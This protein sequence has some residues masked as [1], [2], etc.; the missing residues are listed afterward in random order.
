MFGFQS[1]KIVTILILQR[2]LDFIKIKI[3]GFCGIADIQITLQSIKYNGLGEIYIAK[4]QAAQAF[5]T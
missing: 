5:Q 4:N 1:F 3:R 2:F